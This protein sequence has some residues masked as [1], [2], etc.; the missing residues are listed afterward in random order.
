MENRYVELYVDSRDSTLPVPY[1]S[2]LSQDSTSRTN[3]GLRGTTDVVI[4]LLPSMTCGSTAISLIDAQIPFSFY[5]L[6]SSMTSPSPS[7]TVPCLTIQKTT[8]AV[9]YQIGIPIGN[10]TS[11]EIAA[12]L[13]TALNTAW[14]N[15]FVVS[16][17]VITNKFTISGTLAFSIQFASFSTSLTTGIA[18]DK[19]AS[20]LGFQ[21]QIDTASAVSITSTLTANVGG[22]DYL[23]LRSNLGGALF[24]SVYKTEDTSG[25]NDIMARIPINVNRNEIIQWLNPRR[26]FFTCYPQSQSRYEFWFT[27]RDSKKP[28]QFNGQPFSLKIGMMTASKNSVS[29]VNQNQSGYAISR[30]AFI[31]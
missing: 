14:A 13:Q 5:T 23:Y 3:A 7:G 4:A 26:E 15:S 19:W 18:M 28:V 29:I 21:P 17:S 2:G 1:I 31:N 20:F 8:G 9:N 16:F 10:Y 24:E 25:D 6:S 11:D 30:P 27:F 22:E 12:V